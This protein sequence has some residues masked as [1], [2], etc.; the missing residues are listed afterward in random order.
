ML[1]EEDV[2]TIQRAFKETRTAKQRVAELEAA[3]AALLKNWCAGESL[4]EM[5][6]LMDSAETVLRKK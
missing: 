1:T 5:E 2:E 6:D 4:V 3:L